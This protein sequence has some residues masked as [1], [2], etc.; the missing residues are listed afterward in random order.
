MNRRLFLMGLPGL[1]GCA[2]NEPRR[3]NVFNWSDYVAPD[4]IPNFEKEFGV[5]V[6]YST[7]ESNEEM[8]AKVAAGNSGWDVVFPSN[9][10]ILPMLENNLLAPLDHQRLPGLDHLAKPFR[11][12]SWDSELRWCVPY[13]WGGTGIVYSRGAVTPAPESWADLWSERYSGRLTMLDD[14]AEVL[15]A[16]LLKLGYSLNSTDAGELEQAKQEA[17]AQKKFLR[18]YLNAEVQDQLVAG[19]ILTAQL[20]ATT[21][22]LAMNANAELAFCYPSEGFPLYTDNAAVL[23]ESSQQELA[24]DF[25]AYLLRPGVAA[26]VATKTETAT[27]NAAALDKMPQK[28]RE[29]TT[30]FPAEQTLERGEWFAT[31]TADAQQLRDRL[32]TEIKSA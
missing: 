14:P 13:M 7:Y 17:I 32:W 31:M 2:S 9:Y 22:T 20:W 16:C 1:L 18:A 21:A 10:L 11:A 24:H 15:A 30:L 27:V 29:N 25:L 23:R 19:D 12:P 26:E 28:L 3:L 8:L 5:T 6:R 4:T